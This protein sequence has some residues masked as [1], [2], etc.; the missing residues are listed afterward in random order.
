MRQNLGNYVRVNIGHLVGKKS[1][2]RWGRIGRP[3]TTHF[4]D[5]ISSGL[6]VS[7]AMR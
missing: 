1:R 2:G 5:L 6:L 3:L 7:P 4:A